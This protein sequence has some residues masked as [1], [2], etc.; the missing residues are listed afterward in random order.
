MITLKE[1]IKLNESPVALGDYRPQLALS[2]WKSL[3]KLYSD[4]K[5]E[6]ITFDNSRLVCIESPFKPTKEMFAYLVHDNVPIIATRLLRL[7]KTKLYESTELIK[8]PLTSEKN[9]TNELYYEIASKINHGYLISDNE[10]TTA[11]IAVWKKFISSGYAR[12][13]DTNTKTEVKDLD[14][15]WCDTCSNVILIYSHNKNFSIFESTDL[16]EVNSLISIVESESNKLIV[17]SR[18]SDIL[19]KGLR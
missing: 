3:S 11:S 17:S 1:F 16:I 6:K 12:A 15:I 13:I 4:Y 10:Q 9:L 18:I 2:S 19:I 14:K 7:D 5:S 8:S